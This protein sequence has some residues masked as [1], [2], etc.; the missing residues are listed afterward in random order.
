MVR[1]VNGVPD[2]IYYS[3]HSSGAAFKYSAVEK[4]G[5]RPVSY[6]AVGTHANYAVCLHAHSHDVVLSLTTIQ[7]RR[8]IISTIIRHLAIRQTKQTRDSF[9]TSPRISEVSGTFRRTTRFPLRPAPVLEETAS[10]QRVLV[11]SILAGSGV[12]RSGQL[13]SLGSTVWTASVLLTT[14]QQV[15]TFKRTTRSG[16]SH[17]QSLIIAYRHW[18]TQ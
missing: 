11:G 7:R 8:A 13:P 16:A 18:F 17:G 12:T 5:D 10:L 6:I 3:E 2:V 14:V 4:V 15:S 1:F 9:G